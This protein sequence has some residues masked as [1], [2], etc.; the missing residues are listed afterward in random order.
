MKNVSLISLVSLLSI[1]ANSF[2]ETKFYI[3]TDPA[4]FLMSG[5]SLHLKFSNTAMP[6]WRLGIGT[7][8]LEMPDLLVDINKA[9]K[10]KNWNVEITRGIG[11]FAEYYFNPDLTGWMVGAQL[12]EQKMEVNRLQNTVSAEFKNGMAMASLGYRYRP[13]DSSFYILPW[14]G[15]GYTKTTEGKSERL[16]AG[17]D[18]DP[19]VG[20]MTL[21]IGYE[22]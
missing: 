21:H 16:A 11:F 7:Y 3:E 18:V 4:T 22:F 15:M 2:A 9:N 20:F 8:S 17:Y 6:N 5:D 14:V 10:D 1:S 12:S 13:F 19:W